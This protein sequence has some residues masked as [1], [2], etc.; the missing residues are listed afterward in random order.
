MKRRTPIILLL[1]LLIIG[2]AAVTTTIIINSN[3]TLGFNDSDFKVI[4]SSASSY[5]GNVAISNDNTTISYNSELL[6]HV[7]DYSTITYTVTNASLLY[8]ANISL[9]ITDLLGNNITSDYFTITE[10]KQLPSTLGGTSS[11]EGEIKIELINTPMSTYQYNFKVTIDATPVEREEADLRSSP[12]APGVYD[13][14][15]NMLLS[16]NELVNTYGLDLEAGS[17]TFSDITAKNTRFQY[18]EK[19]IVP[20]G[21]TY[22]D[23]NVFEFAQGLEEIDLPSTLV[24]IKPGMFEGSAELTTI[25][26]DEGNP[27][28]SSENGIV[29]DKDQ[30]KLVYY[31]EGKAKTNYTI[32]EN[33]E[34]IG[35]YALAHG[36][37]SRLNIPTNVK[38]IEKD[39]FYEIAVD[40]LYFDND[41]N[42]Y[43]DDEPVDNND[44]DSSSE[45]KTYIKNHPGTWINTSVAGIYDK[46]G[47]FLMSWET[48]TQDYEV[49]FED[50]PE[51]RFRDSSEWELDENYYEYFEY[52]EDAGKKA[53]KLIIGNDITELGKYS[54]AFVDLE[55]VVLPDNITKISEGVFWKANKLK[56][57]TL[58]PNLTSIG[59][60]A[61]SEAVLESITIP[62][63]V[64]TIHTRAFGYNPL[65]SVVFENPNGWKYNGVAVDSSIIS[66]PT[67]MAEYLKDYHRIE[68]W[69]R[70]DT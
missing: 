34:T 51:P 29:F 39:A 38:M 50:K 43:V 68:N 26:V 36:S 70:S 45:A 6:S 4:F 67:T 20:E 47:I 54:L 42:W 25:N 22:I 65:T 7:G 27:N 33:V 69:T 53:T 5:N 66:N 31:P 9:N 13:G 37:F 60:F 35:T 19:I 52:N 56:K 18:I 12:D 64:T 46:D 44:I 8:D 48:L 11:A 10:T 59:E 15:G 30:K 24:E 3:A 17:V 1:F 40:T 32:P 41:Y 61:F 63:S 16:W 55:E 62:S 2:F 21:V 57:I 58:S 23:E 28:Y 49:D 14:S